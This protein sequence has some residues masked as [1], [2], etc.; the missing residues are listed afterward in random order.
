MVMLD[1]GVKERAQRERER[2]RKKRQ[3][4]KEQGRKGAGWGHVSNSETGQLE[5]AYS[6]TWH[7]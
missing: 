7:F 1:T 2:K 5:T 3:G 6:A 4:R